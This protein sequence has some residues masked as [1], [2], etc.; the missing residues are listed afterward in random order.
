MEI[1]IITGASSGLG[2]AYAALA[3]REGLDA[4]W[5]SGR[6]QERLAE[7]STSLSV[8]C[9]RFAGALTDG[10]VTAEREKALS[11]EKPTV[12]Y[13][14]NAAGFG[15]LAS[16]EKIPLA[17]QQQMIALNC[18]AAVTMTALALPYMERGCHITEIASVAGFQPIPG[19][20][21]Y[22][23]TKA[24]L[25][26]YSRALAE[27]LRP[28]GITVTAVCPYWISDT[29]FIG[30]ARSLDPA[31]R[32]HFFL[33]T[34]TDFVAKKSWQAVKNGKTVVTPGI[35]A[36]IAR[37]ASKLLPSGLIMT[38]SRLFR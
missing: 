30:R 37:I 10:A 5:L 14:V 28:R 11:E 1:A 17:T 21:L 35:A 33:A 32:S 20:A 27:E 29:D 22:A 4:L 6:R 7:L 3:A 34:H 13:L 8:P 15:L 38:V 36:H 26:R 16:S 31:S 9:R 19:L 23:A 2:R 12:R 25:Y 24:F 18:T